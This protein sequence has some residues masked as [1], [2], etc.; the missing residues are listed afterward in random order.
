MALQAR[1]LALKQCALVQGRG[2][3]SSEATFR[4]QFEGERRQVDQARLALAEEKARAAKELE[5]EVEKLQQEV[6]S[7]F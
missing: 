2:V 5:Q 3:G 6:N 7:A 1:Q 4:A